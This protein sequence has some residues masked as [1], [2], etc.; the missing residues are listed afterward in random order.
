LS[1]VLSPG[2]SLSDAISTFI[3][4]PGEPDSKIETQDPF[5]PY[6]TPY[7]QV[8]FHDYEYGDYDEG[9]GL[10]P[11]K[12]LTYTERIAK[13]FDGFKPP[14]LKKT[15]RL[16]RPGQKLL[17]EGSKPGALDYAD[18]DTDDGDNLIFYNQNNNGGASSVEGVVGGS[19][20]PPLEDSNPPPP[21]PPTK[22]TFQDAIQAIRNNESF[23]EIGKK[24][25]S[26]ASTLSERSSGLFRGPLFLMWTVPTTVFALLGVFYTFSAIAI[27]AYKYLTFVLAN[28][29]NQAISLI[30]IFLVFLVPLILAIFIVT[31]RASVKGELNVSR[32]IKGDLEASMRQDF[33]GV[34]FTMD[35]IFGSSALLGLGWLVSITI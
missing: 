34:D 33:D 35:A 21:R 12:P 3:F 30:P 13:W 2:S 26:A 15:R 20:A 7:Q 29:A 14:S 25:F 9:V 8:G 5:N 27:V 19:V 23:P 1:A 11:P 22:Y 4:G 17:T 32:F 31:T 18:Y 6:E 28:D 10:Y 16:L 24:F